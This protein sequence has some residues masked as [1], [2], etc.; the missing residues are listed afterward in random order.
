MTPEEEKTFL[1]WQSDCL[2]AEA[3]VEDLD[4][5]NQ[6]FR[7]LLVRIEPMLTDAQDDA[8]GYSDHDPSVIA[9]ME[10]VRRELRTLLQIGLSRHNTL[11]RI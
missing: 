6:A 10:L 11:P 4:R 9:E 8:A 5:E 1:K 7:A 2:R 3:T